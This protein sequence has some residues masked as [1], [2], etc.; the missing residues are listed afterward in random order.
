MNFIIIYT[1]YILKGLHI[2]RSTMTFVVFFRNVYGDDLWHRLALFGNH[3]R[4]V[5]MTTDG[6]ITVVLCPMTDQD[7]SCLVSK[8]QKVWLVVDE[9]SDGVIER[10]M[11]GSSVRMAQ[12]LLSPTFVSPPSNQRHL[13]KPLCDHAGLK[14]DQVADPYSVAGVVMALQYAFA[15]GL[16]AFGAI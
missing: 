14:M 8:L 6:F 9:V 7:L 5:F 13:L 10:M 15:R 11:Q 3:I 2:L 16:V 1:A 12:F 4:R